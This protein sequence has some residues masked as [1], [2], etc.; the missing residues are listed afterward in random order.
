MKR[1]CMI[2]AVLLSVFFPA[3]ADEWSAANDSYADGNYDDAIEA[4]ENIIMSGQE[5]AALYYNLGN[6]YYRKG[7]LASAILNYERSLK[8]EPYNADA[9][10]NLEFARSRT[11]DKIDNAGEMLLSRW[12]SD[13]RNVASSDTWAYAGVGLFVFMLVSL[14]AY[15]F[16]NPLWLR[17][18]GFSLSVISLFFCIVTLVF[19]YQQKQNIVSAEEAIVFAPTVTVKSTPDNSG[20]DLFILHEGTKVKV[21]NSVGGWVEITMQDGNSG[22][23]PAKAVEII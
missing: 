23:L 5:S 14:S 3:A 16:S 7:N 18:T 9:I 10:H 21:G 8:L 22:W 6:A 12:W 4:Y 20:A 11:V 2:A 19:S 1:F 15:L 13:C 17:K